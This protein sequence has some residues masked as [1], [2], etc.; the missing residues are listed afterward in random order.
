MATITDS[1]TTRR[2]VEQPFDLLA[3]GELNRVPPGRLGMLVCPVNCIAI[4]G[5]NPPRGQR[6]TS[7]S[8]SSEGRT[9]A[10]PEDCLD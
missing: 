3:V 9:M 5:A 6:F 8:A 2:D 7:K 1:L 4:S 10:A